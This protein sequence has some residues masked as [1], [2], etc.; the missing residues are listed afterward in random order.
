MAIE[1]K[2]ELV[3]SI[4]DKLSVAVGCHCN[5]SP[6]RHSCSSFSRES[7]PNAIITSIDVYWTDIDGLQAC[8]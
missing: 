6:T 4:G 3:K 1:S 7:S 2:L 8:N 5:D